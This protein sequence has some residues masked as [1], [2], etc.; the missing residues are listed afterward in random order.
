MR[1]WHFLILGILAGFL[2]IA[3]Y[4]DYLIKQFF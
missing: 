1:S 2:I 3:F 4:I